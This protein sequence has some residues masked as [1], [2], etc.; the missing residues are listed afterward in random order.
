MLVTSDDRGAVGAAIVRTAWRYRSELTPVTATLLLALCAAWG[1]ARN[2]ALG[3]AWGA[4]TAAATA[5][6]SIRPGRWPLGRWLAGRSAVIARPLERRYAAAVVGLSGAWLSAATVA[7]PG[8]P[9]LPAVAVLG[10]TAAGLPWWFHH[11][12]RA[13][14]RVERTIAAWPTFA[15][16]VGLPGST[17]DSA[18]VSRWGW[19]ARLA[20]RRG[21]TAAHAIAAAGP[22]ESA[23]G[24]RPGA[25]RVEPDPHRADRAILRVIETDPHATPVA[26]PGI[27]GTRVRQ[28]GDGAAGGDAGRSRSILDP[29]ELG[30]YEDGT[31]ALASLAYR[32][33]LI[34]GTTGAG[35][36]GLLNV[37]LATLVACRDVVI[38]G[39][40]L[41]GGME[42]RPWT[43]CLGRLATTPAGAVALL[44]D[45]RAV[46]D[47]RTAT[48]TSRLW[49]PSPAAPA[50]VIVV[51]EFA[52]LPQEA[53]AVAESIARV[54][55]AVMVNLIMATQ[56]P[57]QAAM[58]GGAT[59]SQ[60][61]VRMCL[62]VAEKRDGELVLD[63]G[64]RAEG[65]LP[66]T[67]DAPGKFLLR[68]PEHKAPRPIRAYL[69]GDPDIDDHA[70]YWSIRRP[71]LPDRPGPQQPHPASPR[72]A[73]PHRAP[74]PMRASSRRAAGHRSA[75]HREHRSTP[76]QPSSTPPTPPPARPEP[77]P[78]PSRLLWEAL[79]N[80]PEEGISITDLVTATGMRRTWVY[81][82][83]RELAAHDRATRG[84]PR[85]H[86]QAVHHPT[87]PTDPTDPTRPATTPE[88]HGA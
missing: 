86:W 23:L 36:S 17:V 85:G 5:I 12:R 7:G 35:K 60:A 3:I 20:L 75:G 50:L 42:L 64:S 39:I 52:E 24:V 43:G 14:V 16:A 82:R 54:G 8:T 9:P 68:D 28:A 65:W 46:R 22:I 32:N 37:I 15:D 19:T 56:R 61:D 71:L 80:A 25:V 31:P 76:R 30:P 34:G 74:R 11:R 67:L 72:P 2:P 70:L 29:V 66:D 40:D 81:D 88:A 79:S 38:W 6:L 87:N 53:M 13:R 48:A 1:H 62:R 10:M 55:R 44:A 27:P 57:A 51:D 18:T 4:A 41:K 21:H 83:L 63:K 45:A 58:G 59:R 77:P 26:W 33:V 49:Q 69:I 78:D 47:Q 84:G 73:A